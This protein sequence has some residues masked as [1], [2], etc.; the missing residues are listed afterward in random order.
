MFQKPIKLD[1]IPQNILIMSK[2][3]L[4][5]SNIKQCIIFL[6]FLRIFS[7][8][9]NTRDTNAVMIGASDRSTFSN[10]KKKKKKSSELERRKE[11]LH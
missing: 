3:K 11:S 6:E 7:S 2:I 9:E 10:M 8:F 1:I 5:K 4:K